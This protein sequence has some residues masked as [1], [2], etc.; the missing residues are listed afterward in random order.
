MTIAREPPMPIAICPQ[1]GVTGKPFNMASAALWTHML[2][3]EVGLEPG[4]LV[5]SFGD[6]H[7]YLN[8]VGQVRE[9]MSREP[10]PLPRLRLNP[11]LRTIDEFAAAT[12]TLEDIAIDGYHPWPSIKAP[13]AV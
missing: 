4:K 9:Q 10:R 2:A 13:V 12:T 11:A 7:I 3:R 8:H 6:L 5:H 1:M